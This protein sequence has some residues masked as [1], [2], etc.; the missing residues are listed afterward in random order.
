MVAQARVIVQLNGGP[1]FFGT[2]HNDEYDGDNLTDHHL[3]PPLTHHLSIRRT[4]R[5]KF[6]C[7]KQSVS[8][9]E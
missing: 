3:L 9:K 1:A 7:E 4:Y 5:T 2:T 6:K 8:L